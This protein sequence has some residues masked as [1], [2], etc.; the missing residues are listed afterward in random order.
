MKTIDK[1]AL[2]FATLLILMAG[3]VEFAPKK[4]DIRS[5]AV[6]ITNRDMN[7]GGTGLIYYSSKSKSW[8]LTN[9]HVCKV[10]KEGGMVL[11][12]TSKYQ[13]NSIVESKQSD[14]CL[15]SVLDNLG[16]NTIVSKSAPQMYDDV[17][18]SGFP[19]LMPNVVSKGHLSGRSVIPVFIGVKPCTAEDIAND[20][21]MCSFVGGIPI[22]KFYESVLTSATIMPGNSGSGVYN[23]NQELI[24]LVFAG[25]GDLG[26][27]WT[28]PYEQVVNF[29]NEVHTLQ[30]QFIDQT[31][32]S[33]TQ[34]DGQAKITKQLVDKCKNERPTNEKLEELC[35]LVSKDMI[36]RK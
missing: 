20:P 26:Y 25:Q 5:N 22:V 3:Y 15:L 30:E 33:K 29:L 9:D 10:A 16:S 34:D 1:F 28:V 7:H 31:L 23:S 17:Q 27:S 21:M 35:S 19:A 11:S 6:M 32:Q 8:I 24:G 12:N 2:G 13:V 14:L 4:N 18:V 36:W